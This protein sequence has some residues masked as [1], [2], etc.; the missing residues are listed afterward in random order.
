MNIGRVYTAPI[1][2]ASHVEPSTMDIGARDEYWKGVN[3]PTFIV[4]GTDPSIGGIGA[5]DA[6]WKGVQPPNFHPEVCQPLNT[7]YR[8]T[9]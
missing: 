2:I 4:R 7:G 1:F 9:R 8:G 3:P 6:Y 5:H